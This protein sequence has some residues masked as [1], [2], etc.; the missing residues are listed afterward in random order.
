MHI[1]FYKVNYEKASL[2]KSIS[3]EKSKRILIKNNNNNNNNN[4]KRE[5]EVQKNFF[6]FYIRINPKL[7]NIKNPDKMVDILKIMIKR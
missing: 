5:R 6:L 7:I 4:K 2:P 3:L 1:Q